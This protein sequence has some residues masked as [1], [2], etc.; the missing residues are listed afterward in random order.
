MN[1][2]LLRTLRGEPTPRRPLWIMRQAGRY[3]PEYRALRARH[4]FEDLAGTPALAAEVTLQPLARFP[5]DAAIIFADLMSPIGALGLETRFD[6]GPVL[7]RPVRTAADVASLRD[8]APG[9]ISPEVIEALRLVRAALDRRVAL[10]GFAGAPWSLAAYLVQGQ[11]A[12]GF[13]A[14]RALLAH[15]GGLLN[16]LLGRLTELVARYLAAQVAAGSDAVQV[17]DTWA[18]LLSRSDWTRVVLPHMVRLLE[19]TRSLGVPRILFVHDAPHLVDDYAALAAEALAVDWREDLAA[20]RSRVG[21][22]ALQGNLDPAILLAGPEPTRRA[23]RELLA[24]TP[25]TGHIVNLG[26]GILPETPLE[27][28]HALVEVVHAEACQ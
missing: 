10:L 3:L 20:L 5:F 19:A 6:P 14:L 13:P 15:D 26:H 8:P 18:G 9:E 7:T 25:P 11:G 24:R 22:R 28:V 21:T 4:R 27:S 23:A 2:L 17:F 16:A 12:P 1:N